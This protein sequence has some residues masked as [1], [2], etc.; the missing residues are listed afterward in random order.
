[1]RAPARTAGPR[2][3]AST[4]A[5]S[6]LRAHVSQ[7]E[8]PETGKAWWAFATS[9]PPFLLIWWLMY[10]A[11]E[12]SYV[13]T[14]LLAFPAA[15]FVVRTFIVQHDC[16][17]GTFF[18]S[19]R[20][21]NNIG[22]L[23]SLF[24]LMPYGYFRH[25][26][27]AHHATSGKLDDR[28][29][30]IET[31]T[32]REYLAL[33]PGRRFRYRLM[34]HPLALFGVAPVLYFVLAMRIPWCARRESK[35]ERRSILYT[36]AALGLLV[37][38]VV[39]LVG[40]KAFLLVQLPITLIAAT[41]GMWL[42]YVQHQF[43]DT[44]WAPDAEWDY[45][46]AAMEGSSHYALPRVLEWFTGGIGYHHIHHLSPRVPS[47]RLARCHRETTLFDGVPRITLRDGFRCARLALWDEQEGR[48]V[49]LAELR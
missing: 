22:R 41:A 4:P 12:F 21:R 20:L 1:M 48:L 37:W 46:K 15:G 27:G 31:L 5:M 10:R 40:L 9:L 2:E 3:R 13:L 6:W 11:L 47:Y 23:C 7:Y 19:R 36:N 43:E 14:L 17:H 28:G 38:A 32:V 39:A 24:T 34:R 33:S 16:G 8:H 18:T 42:F 35:R 44:Y 49:A 30:D 25:F 29:F 45:A 26:H